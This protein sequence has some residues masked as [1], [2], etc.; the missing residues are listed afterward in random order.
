MEIDSP[1]LV[2]SGEPLLV[3]GIDVVPFVDA[4]LN[5]RFPGRVLR[6][7]S[8]PDGLREAWEA[9]Q[10]TWS[11]TISRVEQMPTGSVDTSIDGEWSFAQ[12][13]R[14]L[15]MATDVWLGRAI[16]TLLPLFLVYIVGTWVADGAEVGPRSEGW[17]W[18]LLMALLVTPFQA[19][20]EE[21]LFRGWLMLAVGTWIR[22]PAVAVPVA[23]VLSAVAFALAHGSL[24]PWI[25]LD[26]GTFAVAAVILTWRTGGLEAALALHVVNNVVLLSVGTLAG[27]ASE[28]YVDADAAQSPASALLSMAVVTLATALLLWQARRAGIARTVPASVGARP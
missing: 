10:H 27:F 13:L 26:L 8:D 12:T 20:G 25:L 9:L 23:A 6:T 5:K 2:E 4:E 24:D 7:A 14:H 11:A 21:Y 15:V 16:L 28:S 18:L 22:R 17:G 1:W 3:N 19:A